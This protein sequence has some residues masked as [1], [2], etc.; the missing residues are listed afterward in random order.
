M[1]ATNKFSVYPVVGQKVDVNHRTELNKDGSVKFVKAARE[2]R[3][4][5]RVYLSEAGIPAVQDHVGDVWHVK[6]GRLNTWET[7]SL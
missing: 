5:K 2:E 1:Q 3:V 6:P 7:I 4:I